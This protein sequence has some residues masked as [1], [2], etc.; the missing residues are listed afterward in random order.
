MNIDHEAIDL[1][2]ED[3]RR[4]DSDFWQAMTRIDPA[5]VPNVW[6]HFD[7]SRFACPCCGR[8]FSDA[9]AM[10]THA[11]LA[12]GQTETEVLPPW[13]TRERVSR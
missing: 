5:S 8:T 13:S 2:A 9:T 4:L 7:G 3:R 10:V 11:I 1:T 6:R 12:H